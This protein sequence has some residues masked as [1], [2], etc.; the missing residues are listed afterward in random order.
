[1]I[2]RLL[3]KEHIVKYL[4][5][6]VAQNFKLINS[7]NFIISFRFAIPQWKLQREK[8]AMHCEEDTSIQISHVC[9]LTQKCRGR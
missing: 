4:G 2:C 6:N 8:S 1:M 5:E 7:I 3:K 9:F